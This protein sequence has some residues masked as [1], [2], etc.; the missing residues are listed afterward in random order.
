MT[1]THYTKS[2]ALIGMMGAGKTSLGRKLARQLALKFC[3]SDAAIE[4]RSGLTITE[5]FSSYGEEYFRKAEYSV[6]K[7]LLS[8][9]QIVL[10]TGGGAFT[11]PDTREF[12]KEE[13]ITIWLKIEFE[14]LWERL[15]NSTQRPLLQTPNPRQSLRELYDERQPV[16]AQADIIVDCSELNSSE[17]LQLMQN[18]IDDWLS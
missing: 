17:T 1:E 18:S 8:D 6:I 2:I 13:T 10:A 11:H 5:V 4:E 9:S 14:T 7:R 3:D 15:K 12:L 16:Y